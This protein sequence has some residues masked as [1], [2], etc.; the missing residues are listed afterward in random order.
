MKTENI[1]VLIYLKNDRIERRVYAFSVCSYFM[2]E[3]LWEISDYQKT[4]I[5][6]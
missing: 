1:P 2:A 6:D 4:V 3:I 5:H